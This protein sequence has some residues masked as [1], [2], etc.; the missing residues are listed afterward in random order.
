M[1]RLV[2]AA[3]V[4]AASLPLAACGGQAF[5]RPDPKLSADIQNKQA[6]TAQAFYA[7]L[8]QRLNHCTIIGN[9]DLNLK[10]SSE[11]GFTNTAGLNCPAKPWETEATSSAD[12]RAMIEAAVRD[13]VTEALE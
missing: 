11:A 3:A 4:A 1:K 6:E 7:A 10:V 5:I 13:A 2:F 9:I 12:L 8:G